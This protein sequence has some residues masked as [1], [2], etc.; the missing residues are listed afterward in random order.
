MKPHN[1]SGLPLIHGCSAL[2]NREVFFHGA[3]LHDKQA[4]Q[5][6]SLFKHTFSDFFTDKSSF[7]LH[8]FI[9]SDTKGRLDCQAWSNQ[10][11]VKTDIYLKLSEDGQPRQIS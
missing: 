8:L 1:L 10:N 2:F 9:Q 6:D 7:P 3:C 5:L 11:D 4:R